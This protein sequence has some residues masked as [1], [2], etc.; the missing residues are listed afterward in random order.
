MPRVITRSPTPAGMTG[1]PGPDPGPKAAGHPR[2]PGCQPPLILHSP[3]SIPPKTPLRFT[4]T[5]PGGPLCLNPSSLTPAAP[6]ANSPTARRPAPPPSPSTSAR[7]PGRASS[8]APCCC[9]GSS[10]AS[11]RSGSS[12]RRAG[13]GSASGP[14]SSLTCQGAVGP[15]PRRARSVLGLHQ[16][17][18]GVEQV[19]VTFAAASGAAG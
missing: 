6:S 4:V 5:P 10:P 15:L 9:T 7:K 18:L 17:S 3:F 16:L 14:A 2:P 19:E 11:G 1:Y 8:A 12:W 13:T